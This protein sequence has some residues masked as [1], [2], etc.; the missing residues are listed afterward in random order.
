MGRKRGRIRGADQ[1][2]DAHGPLAGIYPSSTGNVELRID[3]FQAHSYEVY[4]NGV[5]SSHISADP[6]ELAYE[7]MRWITVGAN[8]YIDQHLD[9]TKLRITHLGGGACTLAR[10]MVAKYPHSRNTV[11]ELDAELATLVRRWF[12]LPRAPQL[13]IRVGDARTVTDSF[14]P[15]S[16]DIVIRDVFAGAVT[17][18][19]LTTVEF[20]RQVATSLSEHGLYIANCGD[21][22][23][24]QLAKNE[25]ATMA[26]VFPYLAVI[27]DPPMLKGRRYGNIILFGAKSQLPV[28]A[29]AAACTRALLHG[30]VPAHYKDDM[31][32]RRF[33]S[34]GRVL[35]DADCSPS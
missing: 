10:Y 28:D 16:R 32:V 12:D 11:V 31:W 22:S 25:L 3:P 21:H 27:A 6:L 29:Y 13:K 9:P 15:H 2:T 30:A 1:P 17:P 34:S 20:C 19:N 5:P 35:F 26:E 8:T 24:L 23:D 18:A 7:Y 14:V 33:A 4:V